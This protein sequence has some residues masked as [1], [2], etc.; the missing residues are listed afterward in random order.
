VLVESI[1]T[2]RTM[3]LHA[4]PAGTGLR[5]LLVT[6]A[7]ARE[8]KTS[9]SGH[10]A[11]SLTRA[12]F[13]TLLIDGDLKSPS[14]H[15]LFG[16]SVGPG[17]CEVLRDEVDVASAVRP[18]PLPGLSVLTAGAWDPAARQAL[19]GDR[20]RQIKQ[21]L[22]S[23]YDF[24]VIDT[25]P[26]LLVSDTLLLAREADGVLLS[27]LLG[28]SQVA[29]VAESANRLQAIGANLSGAVVNGVWHQAYRPGYGSGTR[30]PRVETD[31]P[32][33]EVTVTADAMNVED[34]K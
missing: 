5:T 32:P 8:G 33:R 27:V 24:L 15:R 21:G 10:L 28:V 34:G 13:S 7:V 9:L 26:L 4:T 20:W 22:E 14:V 25:A 12:G 11:I 30:S 31:V 3:L 17:L 19:V 23:R 16:L 6:S 2:T 29:H 1:D 18:S